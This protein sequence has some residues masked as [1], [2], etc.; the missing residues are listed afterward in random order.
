MLI[1]LLVL[2]QAAA[3]ETWEAGA[4]MRLAW[5]GYDGKEVDGLAPSLCVRRVFPSG[6]LLFARWS[7]GEMSGKKVSKS[8]EHTDPWCQLLSL[9]LEDCTWHDTKRTNRVDLEY[10]EVLAGAGYRARFRELDALSTDVFAGVGAL[11]YEVDEE[12]MIVSKGELVHYEEDDRDGWGFAAR[13]GARASYA[14]SRVVVMEGGLDL[15]LAFVRGASGHR[16][17]MA[18]VGGFLGLAVRF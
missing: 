3:T 12:E 13:T 2:T 6:A 10:D 11:R 4:E 5:G 18:T 1:L 17:T 14:L 15:D 8:G 9:G 16:H 7:R